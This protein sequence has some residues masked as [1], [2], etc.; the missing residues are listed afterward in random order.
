MHFSVDIDKRIK[1]DYKNF[2]KAYDFLATLRVPE[3][4]KER[5]I[6]CILYLSE[7]VLDSLSTWV[8]KANVDSRDVIFYAEYD[9]RDERKWNFNIP[10]NQQD[11]YQFRK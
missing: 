1:Q 4:E 9:N 2:H 3:V 7:G 10:F 5:I 6:R 11:E 8:K